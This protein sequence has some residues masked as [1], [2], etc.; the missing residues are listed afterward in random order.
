MSM[1]CG[2]EPEHLQ[3][4]C[5]DTTSTSKRRKFGFGFGFG[6]VS[7]LHDRKTT[8]QKGNNF[9]YTPGCQM[10]ERTVC[11]ERAEDA[12][13]LV[14][15]LTLYVDDMLLWTETSQII[16]SMLKIWPKQT[17]YYFFFTP[18]QFCSSLFL[19]VL[20]Q[21]LAHHLSVTFTSIIVDRQQ[22][23]LLRTYAI[24]SVQH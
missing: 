10:L 16:A 23:F 7:F 17:N 11:L 24:I 15:N 22:L 20:S 19:I 4:T 6:S 12:S 1:D 5:F 9:F 2:W 21:T 8:Q 13:A 14:T 18:S 3:R